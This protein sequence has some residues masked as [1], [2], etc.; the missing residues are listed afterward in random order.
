MAKKKS[1]KVKY[2]IDLIRV[3]ERA[4]SGK[5]Q[6]VR[7][8]L[9]GLMKSRLFKQKFGENVIERIA[10]RTEKKKIDK[11]NKAFFKPYS[12]TYQKSLDFKIYA[13]SPGNVNLKLTGEMLASMRLGRAGERKIKIIMAD[14]FNNAKA[15]GH[16]NGI[17][18][19]FGASKK[20]KG[21]LKKVKRD[22]LG[23]PPEDENRIMQNTIKQF[24]SDT[25]ENLID[26]EKESLDFN[27]AL[28]SV[29]AETETAT[30]PV[31]I[32]AGSALDTIEDAS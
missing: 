22:F 27:V 5:P 2:E 8:K 13:K 29:A 20:S 10:H 4:M 32:G 23:L 18:R 31:S 7:S 26:F 25:I 12:K 1:P 30:G 19:R 16:I 15:H 6:A 9:R 17:K 28:A 24:N 21:R 11:K 3:L 14:E